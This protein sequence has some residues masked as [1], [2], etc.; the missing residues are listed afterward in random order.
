MAYHNISAVLSQA[1][2]DAIK[3]AA[4]VITSK[5]PFAVVLEDA[6]KQSLVKLGSKSLDF[7]EDA[8]RATK[9]FPQ[10][11]PSSFNT[12]E[13]DKDTALFKAMSNVKIIIE[14]LAKK[15]EDTH[16][17]V[18]SEAMVTSFEVYALIGAQKDRVPGLKAVWE[19]MRE[20]FA[21][22]TGSRKKR[23]S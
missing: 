19:K 17:A 8:N 12:V 9:N 14:A 13:F 16:M 6:E 1:D 11:F 21:G 20:R 4:D 10:V 15:I 18:G 22:Q 2:I 3:A 5:L 23:V 7:V